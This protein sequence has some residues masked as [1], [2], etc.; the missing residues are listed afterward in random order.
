MTRP[1]G[2][3]ARGDC[4]R[5]R[6]GLIAQPANT[7]SSLALVA[8]A[9]PLWRRAVAAGDRR[10]QAVAVSSALAGLGSVAYHGPGGRA[11]RALHDGGIWALVCSAAIALPGG[12]RR[13]SWASA[14]AVTLA[15]AGAVHATSRTGGPLCRPDSLLQ[16][17][18]LWHLL[19]AGA[20][21]AAGRACVTPRR[22]AVAGVPGSPRG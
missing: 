13:P 12:E 3:V 18:A 4:E 11:G 6:P 10:T 16:G 20:V 15:A 22:Q 9:V 5:V 21:Y 1:P 7:A 19:S 14:A 17:H 8:V 2:H